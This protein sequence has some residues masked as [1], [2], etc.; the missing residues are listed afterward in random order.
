MAPS[1]LRRVVSILAVLWIGVGAVSASAKPVDPSE[2]K[3]RT[4]ALPKRLEGID[5]VEHLN[6]ELPKHVEFTD[7]HGRRV[8]LGDYFDGKVPVIVT[9][10]YSGCPMLCSLILNGLVEGLKHVDWTAG[11]DFRIVTVSIDPAETPEI[12]L[13][14]KKRYV[15]FYGRQEANEG[16]HF[17]TGSPANVRAVAEAVGF[18]YGY[19]EKRKE[20]VHPAAIALLTP[21]GRIARYLY[22]IEFLPKTLRLSLVEASEG[23]IGTTVDRL[24]LYCFHY[25]SSEGRYAPVAVN[26]MRLG[27]G[28]TAILLGGLLTVLWRGE[29]R[30]RKKLRLAGP[31]QVSTTTPLDHDALG[32]RHERPAT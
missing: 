24:L 18:K 5:V 16:W 32:S 29:L 1:P 28:L 14:T 26:I 15:D 22:G 27:G 11:K 6:T 8:K 19:N 13:R 23:R 25:D 30:K 31:S 10:N 17:L 4:E 21:G 3:E 2:R 12:S 7:E 9:L 20:Y